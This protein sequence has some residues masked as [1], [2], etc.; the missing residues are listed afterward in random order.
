MTTEP[1]GLRE[2]KKQAT[3]QALREAALR[4]ALERGPDNVRVDD[5][6]EAA[7]VSP[8]T[9]NNYFSSREQ[10][11]VAAVTA[12]RESRIAAAVGAHPVGTGLADAVVE[13][14]VTQYTDPDE[15]ARDAL[16]LI[17]TRPA[18]REAFVDSAAA[19]TPPLTA[20]IADRLGAADDHTAHVLA[21]SVA[22]AVHVALE[23][24]ARPVG[25]S[26]PASGLVV[27]SGSLPDLLRS[28]LAPLRPAL[29]AA[30]NHRPQA[31]EEDRRT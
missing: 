14:V 24:W 22:A 21:A 19:I 10:A 6:A 23:R 2:R 13:A 18:L 11:I 26:S 5:I 16:L 3:R 30:E 9:Y 7:G 8:R 29:D 28:A 20:A 1:A 25:A 12:E 4:L 27:P 31:P 17:T 15:D